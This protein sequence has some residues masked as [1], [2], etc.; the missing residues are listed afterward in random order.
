MQYSN[1]SSFDPYHEIKIWKNK[2]CIEQGGKYGGRKVGSERGLI[3][4]EIKRLRQGVKLGQVAAEAASVLKET[5]AVLIH[6]FFRSSVRNQ[7]RRQ[8]P[9]SQA[10]KTFRS[11]AATQARLSPSHGGLELTWKRELW[12]RSIPLEQVELIP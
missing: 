2:A 5:Y 10:R 4:V 8:G 1:P 11:R 12:R 3:L 7:N 9:S 6:C